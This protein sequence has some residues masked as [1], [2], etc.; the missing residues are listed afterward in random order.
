M[1]YLVIRLLLLALV[2]GFS[3]AALQ[4]DPAKWEKDIA[5]FEQKDREN[6]PAPGGVLFAGS[7][8][9]RRWDLEK[10]F[11][12]KHYVNRGFGESQIE[13]SLIYADRFIVPQAPAVL[14]FYAGGNDLNAGKT[15][16]QVFGD[17]KQLQARLHAKLPRLRI[18]YLSTN[19]SIK[20]REQMEQQ[21]R[22][23]AM[24]KEF[25]ARNPLLTYVH[26]FDA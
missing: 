10:S 15:P 8:T 18:L 1:N 12:G 17:F 7:S 5:A 6:P 3:A 14:V 23:N 21:K 20:R 2:F 22:L 19:P 11:P 4:A 26:T 9:V 16:E 24:V 25:C 13:D